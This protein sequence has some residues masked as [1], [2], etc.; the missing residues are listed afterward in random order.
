[1]EFCLQNTPADLGRLLP[2]LEA[3]AREHPLP[4]PVFNAADLALEEHVSNVVSYAYEDRTAH[5]ILIRLSVVDQHLEIE[6]EDDGRP[7]NPLSQPP[8]DV[9]LPLE[10]KPIGGLG[11]HLIRTLMDVV[12]YRRVAGHNI[13]RMRKRMAEQHPQI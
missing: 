9:T 1:V 12:E 4:A 7:F 6:V 5:E 8:V 13:L 10:D 11:V 2:A 3:F